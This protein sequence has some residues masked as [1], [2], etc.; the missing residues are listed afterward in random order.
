MIARFLKK[1]LWVIV[2]FFALDAALIAALP[3]IVPMDKVAAFLQDQVREKTGRDLAFSGV[4]FSIWPNLGVELNQATL[5]N[6]AWA[7]QKNMVS[8]GKAE[9]ALEL[10]PLLDHHIVVKKF[11]LNEPEIYLETA[12]DGRQNWDFSKEAGAPAV[13]NTAPSQRRREV[14]APGTQGYDLQ[15]GQI[16][17]NKGKLIFS[18]QQKKT[19]TGFDDVDIDVTLAD[20]KSPLRVKGGLTYRGKRIALDMDLDKPQDFFEGRASSGAIS[21]KADDFSVEADGSLA[22]QGT[23]LKGDIKVKAPALAEVLSWARNAPQQ[24]LPFENLSF[25]GMARLTKSDIILKET[26]LTLDDVQAKGDLNIG[27]TGKPEIFAR[28]SVNKLNLDRF[29]GGGAAAA[30]SGESG[31]GAQGEASSGGSEWSTAPLDFS[32]LKAVNADL[33]LQTDGFTL[34]GAEVG[35]SA[36]TVQ[37]LNGALV[38]KSSEASL[39]GG[40]FSSAA[41]VNAAMATPTMSFAFNMSGVQAQPV[42]ATFAHFK[43]LSGAAT[44]HV[45]LTSAGDSQKEIISSLAG[46][47][48]VDF[49]NGQLEGIDLVKI[50][51]LVQDHSMAVG[52][53]DGETKFVDLTGTFTVMKG[54]ISN[55]DM[56]MKG[57]VVQATGQGIVD[58]PKKYIQ[59]KATPVLLT[60]SNAPGAKPGLSVPV[61]IQG[62]FSNIK[63]IPD[64]ATTVKNII[65]NPGAA[66]ST[67][68][69]IRDNLKQNP[70]LQGLLGKHGGSLHRTRLPPE[71]QPQPAT[72]TRE[73]QPTP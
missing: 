38:F 56:K 8:L 25:T 55:T 73:P 19:V 33:K 36:L 5:S 52:V 10:L 20:L 15:F 40:R 9:V 49:K 3:K 41:G 24:K 17:I 69:N 66:K 13:P 53:D 46:S 72:T 34:K 1:L 37:V 63:V 26:V 11:I 58:L 57:T 30:S 31:G 14:A 35:P 62:P 45:T 65:K 29:T 44:A 50:A 7:Q 54:I 18:D 60:S 48:D 28:L 2:I 22:T 12:A 51:R 71:T 67:L 70:L 42:L 23:L 59:Y 68:K 47:G 39:F 32:G 6:P 4:N 43:K 16:Q 27:F 64:F 21:V 61:K